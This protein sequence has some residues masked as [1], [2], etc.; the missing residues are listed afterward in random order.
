[1]MC[2]SV[3]AATKSLDKPDNKKI[4]D[5]V[6]TVITYLKIDHWLIF[7][8]VMKKMNDAIQNFSRFLIF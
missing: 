4:D 7:K 5:F 1:M 2:D 3:E 8:Y 6:E